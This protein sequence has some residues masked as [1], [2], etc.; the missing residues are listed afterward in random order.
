MRIFLALSSDVSFF[1][2]SLHYFIQIWYILI[3]FIF[4]VWFFLN[5]LCLFLIL[6]FYWFC[7]FIVR[8]RHSFL[9]C[10]IP[11]IFQFSIFNCG[12]EFLLFHKVCSFDF[13]NVEY[14]LHVRTMYF[15]LL[16]AVVYVYYFFHTIF[17]THLTLSKLPLVQ[18]SIWHLDYALSKNRHKPTHTS[19][20]LLSWNAC[21]CFSLGR[22]LSRLLINCH[23]A[24]LHCFLYWKHCFLVS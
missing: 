6:F 4:E 12:I 20:S 22:M 14:L 23:P 18:W 19:L 16:V 2:L 15:P 17:L 10:L 11:I 24:N 13:S 1:S 8:R 3:Y 5:I 7:S 21:S 9:L